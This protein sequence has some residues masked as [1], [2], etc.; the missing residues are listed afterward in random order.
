MSGY[1]VPSAAPPNE[2]PVEP[3]VAQ[4]E[5]ELDA[6]PAPE[7][8]T[9]SE[10]THPSAVS[11]EEGLFAVPQERVL[12][13]LQKVLKLKYTAVLMYMNYGD[14]VRSHFRD[15]VYDH[16]QAHMLEEREACYDLAMK[17]TALGGEPEVQV[18]KVPSTAS[19]AEMF[20]WVMQAEKT[21]ILQLRELLAV[22]GDNVGLRVLLEN[23]LL[24]DQRHLDDARRMSVPLL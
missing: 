9:A 19:M 20:M 13:S 14:R 22:C 4:P 17:I 7:P 12:A 5:P 8:Q 2:A 1:V 15:T 11:A 21:L 18:A 16:F 3:A 10:G 23:M 24:A 6:N